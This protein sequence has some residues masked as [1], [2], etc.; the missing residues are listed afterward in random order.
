[1]VLHRI[2]AL[3]VL[4]ELSI[5]CFLYTI[6]ILMLLYDAYFLSFS[7]CADLRYSL[8]MA[9]LVSFVNSFNV[10]K[11][12]FYRAQKRTSKSI[13]WYQIIQQYCPLGNNWM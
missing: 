5:K 12:C 3:N 1:M 2:L 11:E 6:L 4:L 9:S 10:Y 13:A 7:I 8:R